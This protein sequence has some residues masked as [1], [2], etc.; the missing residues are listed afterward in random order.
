MIEQSD[1][2][3]AKDHVIRLLTD[4]L[5]R[6]LAANVALTRELDA[7]PI[8]ASTDGGHSPDPGVQRE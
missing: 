8:V 5:L 7:R 2:H 6:A 4:E 1:V 3:A